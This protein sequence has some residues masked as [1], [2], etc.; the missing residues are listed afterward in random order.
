MIVIVIVMGR[1]RVMMTS[2]TITKQ[3]IS[4]VTFYL[5]YTAAPA[6]VPVAVPV[7]VVPV[8][9]VIPVPVIFT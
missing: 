5:Y 1:E 4:P 7:P 9:V 2:Y 3:K 6:V 8:P